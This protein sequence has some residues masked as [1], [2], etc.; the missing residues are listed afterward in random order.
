[1][2]RH[3]AVSKSQDRPAGEGPSGGRPVRSLDALP[4]WTGL[5]LTVAEGVNCWWL[6]IFAWLVVVVRS[7]MAVQVGPTSG[8][9]VHRTRF[10]IFVRLFRSV[11]KR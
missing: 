1:M 6:T 2:A 8:R 11:G 10:G 9:R 7:V 4:L 3:R 5:L